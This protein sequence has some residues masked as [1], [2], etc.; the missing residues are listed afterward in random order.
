MADKKVTGWFTMNGKHIPVFEGES[1]KDAVKRSISN[2]REHQPVSKGHTEKKWK[3]F[4]DASRKAEIMHADIDAPKYRKKEIDKAKEYD[5]AVE[6]KRKNGEITSVKIKKKSIDEKPMGKFEK[7][8]R[9]ELGHPT[10]KLTKGMKSYIQIKEEERRYNEG[11]KTKWGATDHS[12]LSQHSE[13][14]KM[15]DDHIEK[16]YTREGGVKNQELVDEADKFAKA[17]NLNVTK[18]RD[19]AMKAMNEKYVEAWKLKEAGKDPL[20]GVKSR[21]EQ[22]LSVASKN[23][24]IKAKQIAQAKKQADTLN[25]KKSSDSDDKDY[26]IHGNSKYSLSK[27]GKDVYLIVGGKDGKGQSF[28]YKVAYAKNPEKARANLGGTGAM[29]Y[30]NFKDYPELAKLLKKL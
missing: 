28:K 10:G 2:G 24:D 30:L 7:E 22:K 8:I 1:K 26:Y 21:R 23:E 15:A 4:E 19:A 13:I 6:Q 25:G 5:K 18:V 16:I 3:E 29:A 20:S 27:S 9:D 14:Q 11:I 17:N 12:K